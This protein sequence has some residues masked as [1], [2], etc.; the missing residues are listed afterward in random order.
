MLTIREL[1]K[2]LYNAFNQKLKNHRGNWEQNDPTADDYIK[3]RP[4]YTD[5]YITV[6]EEKTFSTYDDY[7]WCSPFV[8]ELK[9]NETYKIIW[10]EKEYICTTYSDDALLLGNI[11]LDG[12]S[13]NTGEPFFYFYWEEE[14]YSAEYGFCVQKSGR[15]TVSIYKQNVKKIDKKYIDINLPNNLITENDLAY[16][17][18]SGD[19][20]DLINTPAIYTD[21]VRY[22]TG[23]SL[24]TAQKKTGKANIGAV[25]YDA[26]QGLTTANKTMARTNIGAVGYEAQT[27]TTEQKTQARTNIGASN[28]S[29]DYNDLKNIPITQQYLSTP[30]IT[31][32]Q[33]IIG[34]ILK[35]NCIA[36]NI[37]T[38]SVELDE[39]LW[40]ETTSYSTNET[41]YKYKL[42]VLKALDHNNGHYYLVIGVD[43]SFTNQNGFCEYLQ[44]DQGQ[45]YQTSYFYF[46]NIKL[47]DGQPLGGFSPRTDYGNIFLKLNS[48]GTYDLYSSTNTLKKL[49]IIGPYKTKPIVNDDFISS[50]KE[51][52]LFQMCQIILK[53]N[54]CL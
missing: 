30:D 47:F 27:L 14:G 31:S 22:N 5:G 18:F 42:S 28:F 2:T 44:V 45:S 43:N 39:T 54:K 33:Y 11:S 20:N 51:L 36:N 48:N 10:D 26:S 4:F 50:N 16:V 15:H 46:G 41:V 7:E 34:N 37:E 52:M 24:T 21:V 25:G 1:I 19:Y 9:A 40:T 38:Q 3:N 6:I 17:A 35:F 13:P 29:G 23:Q 53:L 8:F 49:T 32:S 12:G